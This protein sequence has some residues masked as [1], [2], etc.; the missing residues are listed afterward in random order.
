MAFFTSTATSFQ[1]HYVTSFFLLIITI[2]RVLSIASVDSSRNFCKSDSDCTDK[3]RCYQIH[4]GVLNKLIIYATNQTC[5]SHWDCT[6]I[7]NTVPARRRVCSSPNECAVNE[8]CYIPEGPD[9]FVKLEGWC[10]SCENVKLLLPI[11]PLVDLSMCSYSNITTIDQYRHPNST[12]TVSSE[13]SKGYICTALNHSGTFAACSRKLVAAS[14][15][16]PCFCMDIKSRLIDSLPSSTFPTCTAN[17]GCLPSVSSTCICMPCSFIANLSSRFLSVPTECKKKFPVPIPPPDGDNCSLILEKCS[18]LQ[19][20]KK[21]LDCVSQNSQIELYFESCPAPP[22]DHSCFCF[23]LERQMCN[24]AQSCKRGNVCVRLESRE[25]ICIRTVGVDHFIEEPHLV[26]TL[27]WGLTISL[28]CIEIIFICLK[29]ATV[30]H[31][32]KSFRMIGGACFVIESIAGMALTILQLTIVILMRNYY[33]GIEISWAAEFGAILFVVSEVISVV[34]EGFNV[35]KKIYFEKKKESLLSKEISS[36]KESQSRK[37][38]TKLPLIRR[39]VAK[40]IAIILA[41]ACLSIMLPPFQYVLESNGINTAFPDSLS[42]ETD[43]DDARNWIFILPLS[44]ISMHTIVFLKC[45]QKYWSR[46]LSAFFYLTISSLYIFYSIIAATLNPQES[47]YFDV[48]KFNFGG[49]TVIAIFL[50]SVSIFNTAISG[51]NLTGYRESKKL[52]QEQLEFV[53]TAIIGPVATVAVI[54]SSPF[55][56]DDIMTVITVGFPQVAVLLFPILLEFT[57]P[58]WSMISGFCVRSMIWLV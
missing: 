11:S 56:F 41:T 36:I 48:G 53:E 34:S 21:S 7:S 43:H 4:D 49:S 9:N 12:C 29:S 10:T 18:N 51:F 26:S 50:F 44:Y 52:I 33:M 6:C 20:C 54:V 1:I 16:T 58:L 2:T 15:V 5:I 3:K 22:L 31:T 8:T 14:V 19:R 25:Q 13:C 37:W 27:P 46:I 30:N 17:N 32:K 57:A 28:F 35:R 39:V 45:K 24:I 23:D 40:Y 47:Q 42:S 55:R 38:L